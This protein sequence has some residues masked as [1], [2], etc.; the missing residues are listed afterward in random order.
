MKKIALISTGFL[1]IPAVQGGAV[2][3]LTTILLNQNEINP[4]YEFDVYTISN[5]NL[6]NCSYKYTN[7]IEIQPSV[8]ERLISRIQR[9]IGQGDPTNSFEKALLRTFK[10]MHHKYDYVYVANNMKIYELLEHQGLCASKLIYHMHNSIDGIE[11]TETRARLIG[12]TAKNVLAISKYILSNFKSAAPEANIS[13]LYNCV[14]EKKFLYSA[15]DRKLLRA[16]YKISDTEIVV[17][18]SG[19][20]NKEKGVYELVKAF[21]NISKEKKCRL[22]IV[23][24]TWFLNIEKD[25]YLRNLE[26]IS[27]QLENPIIFTGYIMPDK[28]PQIYSMADMVVIPSMWEEPFGVVALEA[29]STKRPLIITNSGGL[30]EAVDNQ[31][32]IVIDR[33]LDVCRELQFAIE[34]LAEDEGLRQKMG[35]AG[36][37]RIEK[38]GQF[39]YSTYFERFC[40]IIEQ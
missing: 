5:E 24:A 23:G 4:R 21:S 22:V 34:Q 15:K 2:E 25:E 39:H 30:V 10:R 7:I 19:R 9:E 16:K 33:K 12:Y 40:Q 11:K 38:N 27:S 29:M 13:L 28:M 14:D 20:I 17:L 3:V 31:C 35:N 8:I 36:R 18:Y 32:A 6:K 26:V 37:M 1:P